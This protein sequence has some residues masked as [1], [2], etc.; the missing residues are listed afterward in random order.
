MADKLT[1][2]EKAQRRTERAINKIIKEMRPCPYC[3]GP[4][5]PNY[6][7]TGSVKMVNITC[8]HCKSQSHSIIFDESKTILENLEL[9]A[10]FWNKRVHCLKG[11]DARAILL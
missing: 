8:A 6:Y 4:G 7:M 3:G 10:S 9:A 1:E 2:E 11:T 5:K